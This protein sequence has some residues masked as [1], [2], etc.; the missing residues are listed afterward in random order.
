[1]SKLVLTLSEKQSER[2]ACFDVSWIQSRLLPKLSDAFF[3]A[4]SLSKK[5]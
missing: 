2:I 4:L 3:R 5:R 1:M